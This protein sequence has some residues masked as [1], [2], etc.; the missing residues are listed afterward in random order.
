L[1]KDNVPTHDGFGIRRETNGH[2]CRE[3]QGTLVGVLGRP[4]VLAHGALFQQA[5]TPCRFPTSKQKQTYSKIYSSNAHTRT[6]SLFYYFLAQIDIMCTLLG[7]TAPTAE[8]W[9][10]QGLEKYGVIACMETK[11]GKMEAAQVEKVSHETAT[12]MLSSLGGSI[13]QVGP[14]LGS[15]SVS[16]P[17]LECLTQEFAAELK[18]KTDK[19]DTDPHFWMPLTLSKQ[20]YTHLM[21]QKGTDEAESEAHH[22]RMAK[23]KESFFQQQG[24]GGDSALGLFGAVDVGKDACWWDYGQLKLYSKNSLLLLQDGQS[25]N[26]L[27]QFLGLEAGQKVLECTF[28][29]DNA[30]VVDDASYA[31]DVKANSG[32]IEKSL[33]AAVRA[34]EIQASGAIVVNC[35][36]K[37]ITAGPGAILYNILV[38]DDQEIVA[39]AGQVMVGVMDQDGKDFILQ[40]RMDIDGGDAWKKKLDMNDLSFEDVNEKNKG[41]NIVEIQKKRA[42]K[43]ESIASSLGF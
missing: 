11:E 36:A 42:A 30:V 35:A 43:F 10:A 26:L 41:A 24:T 15:F 32:K 18:A 34:T 16:S 29:T 9:K 27:R 2:L 38:S 8:E 23:L 14:S 20:D 19:L 7:D 40:S 6:V 25:A 17:M 13:R 22:D 4:S 28:P 39:E 5:N 37:K 1:W 21:K 3:S 31:L 33:L 12:K